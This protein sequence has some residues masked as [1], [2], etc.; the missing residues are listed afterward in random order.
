MT[1]KA[2][3]E[4][5]PAGTTSGTPQVLLAHHL[6][7]LKHAAERDTRIAAVIELA[8]AA[9]VPTR[10]AVLAAV[11]DVQ[12][13]AAVAA[14]QQTGE[15]RLA[16]AD[17]AA[18]HEL[19]ASVG[20]TATAPSRSS[21][22]SCR[23]AGDRS[24][25]ADRRRRPRR[26]SGCRPSRRTPAAYASRARC[27]R[28]ATP[29]SRR[30]RRPDPRRSPPA[31]SRSPAARCRSRNGRDRRQSLPRRPNPGRGRDRPGRTAGGGFRGCADPGHSSIGEHR[32]RHSGR[33]AQTRS[34]SSP[35]SLLRSTDGLR[36]DAIPVASASRAWSNGVSLL[37]K[38][39]R[40]SFA[41]AASNR[42]G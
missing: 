35:A 3:V 1:G 17:R 40:R 30:R 41:G 21:C 13:A 9:V 5:M 16:A 11:G 23:A 32:R 14:P 34:W 4:A 37:R 20:G 19:R 18:A 6:K 15:Q 36:R 10:A 28:A 33:G 2:G 38:S 27:G 42:S 12:L 31:A 7:Q 29:R 26:R 24:D 8:A 25:A 39:G 22:P